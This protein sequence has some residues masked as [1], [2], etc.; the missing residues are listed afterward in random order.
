MSK[1][2]TVIHEPARAGGSY[3]VK[4]PGEKPE[5]VERTMSESE[6]KKAAAAAKAKPAEAAKPSEGKK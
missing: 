3:V 4:K 1:I 5:M 2:E 6:A